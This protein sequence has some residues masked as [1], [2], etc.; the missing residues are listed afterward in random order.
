VPFVA[1]WGNPIQKIT[2]PV[3]IAAPSGR[4]AIIACG[5]VFAAARTIQAPD[6]LALW[7]A[8][9]IVVGFTMYQTARRGPPKLT[10]PHLRGSDVATIIA[11]VIIVVAAVLLLLRRR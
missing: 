3:E 2:N 6:G 1:S 9:I 7:I 11:W 8:G 5:M 4:S 10:L